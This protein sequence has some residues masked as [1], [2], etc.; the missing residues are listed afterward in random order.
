[1]TTGQ[2]A[3][4]ALKRRLAELSRG[5][6]RAV[7]ADLTPGE[8]EALQHSWEFWAR[9][10]QLPPPG[11][12]RCWLMCSGRGAGKTRAAAEFI[13]AEVEA[14]R[15]TSIA[16]VGPTA[17]AIRRDMIEGGSGL[18]AIA[19]NDFRPEFQPSSLRIVWPQT[20]AVAH[21]LSS[22]ESD[23]I[24][25]LNVSLAWCDE[26]CSWANA[27]ATW[28]MLQLALRIPGPRGDA[29]RICVS[30]TPKPSPLLKAIMVAE[31]TVVT[32]A[33]TD[34]N[35]ANLDPAT[36]A[37][38]HERYG[39]TRLG[40]QELDAELLL[41]AEG[42]LWSRDLLEACRVRPDAQPARY[43]RIVVAIDPPG[44]AS[45]T[46]AEAGIV[47]AGRGADG[48]VYVLADLSARMSPEQW[49]RIAVNAY[50]GWKADR[51][52]AEQNFGGLM[53][54]STIRA[55]DGAVPVK[56]A[57]A[58][59]GKQVRAEPIAALFEQ[60]RAHLVGS[61]PELEDQLCTWDPAETGPSPDRLDALVWACTELS[62]RPPMQITPSAIE[63]MTRGSERPTLSP[64]SGRFSR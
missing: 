64:W 4:S 30:T 21:L 18:L 55:V 57:V 36:L 53:V 13:R 47:V 33:R 16:I 63:T 34:D 23:R 44:G 28:D 24:R 46:S 17:L 1:M 20:G 48:H 5:A 56:M 14:G 38:L 8:Q 32:T 39:G 9:A 29:P 37:Y 10:D 22:E 7:L 40:R 49:A 11:A 52:V 25:G 43:T 58:S 62:A 31:T 19:P 15:H 6:R 61:F 12:W 59:R 41:D 3:V 2:L 60:H 42:A 51:I 26:L 35:R 45:K 50:K 54:E 27:Q